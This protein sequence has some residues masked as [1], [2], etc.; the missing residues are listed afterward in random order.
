MLYSHIRQRQKWG[1]TQVLPRVNWGDLFFDLFYVGATYNVSY[2]LVENPSS[3][4]LLYAAGSFLPLVIMW[5]EKMVFDARFVHE[6]DLFHR[7]FQ[8]AGLAVL[9]I[10]VLHIRPVAILSDSSEISMLTFALCLVLE[11]LLIMTRLVE[12]YFYGVGQ[13]Q[14]LQTLAKRE[15]QENLV[16]LLFFLVSFILAVAQYVNGTSPNVPIKRNLAATA[17]NSYVNE[18]SSNIPI[19]L[20]LLGYVTLQVMRCIKVMLLFPGQGR[21]KE[22]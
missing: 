11:R 2:I 19:W 14:V 17:E 13:R 22:M 7:F 4:G 3:T 20:C 21:H 9:A 15:L 1:D 12:I 18:S 5:V 6:D 8:L 16:P 10:A